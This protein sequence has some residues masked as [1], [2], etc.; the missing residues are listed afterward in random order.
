MLACRACRVPI[1]AQGGCASCKDFKAQLI[2]TDEDTEE[3]PALSDVSYEVIGALRTILKRGRELAADP[4]KPKLFNEGAR[5]IVAA[6]NTLAKTLEAARKLQTDGLSAIRN[7]NFVERAELFI[8][9]YMALP[10]SY[11]FKLRTQMDEQ[12]GQTA[13]ALPARA[14]L[15]AGN[16]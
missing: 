10:P 16:T 6:G 15:P 2:T 14:E 12:E 3:N 8:G 4:K 5:L 13:K 9:W 11:R 1:S 7:M